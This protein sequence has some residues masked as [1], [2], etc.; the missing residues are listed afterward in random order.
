MSPECTWRLHN[1]HLSREPYI[2]ARFCAVRLTTTLCRIVSSVR[3]ISQ[4]KTVTIGESAPSAGYIA[5]HCDCR[6]SVFC[7]LGVRANFHFFIQFHL[8]PPHS[9]IGKKPIGSNCRTPKKV[10]FHSFSV[11]LILCR[12]SK[13]YL[14]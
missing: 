13:S 12:G 3:L 1:T 11:L 10:M 14:A 8:K 6:L 4:A 2:G 7:R 9:R 5:R